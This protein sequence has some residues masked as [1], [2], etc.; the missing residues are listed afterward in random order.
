MAFG[1]G[2]VIRELVWIR[3]FHVTSILYLPFGRYVRSTSIINVQP[4]NAID[5]IQSLNEWN[6]NLDRQEWTWTEKYPSWQEIRQY[7]HFADKKLGIKKDVAFES[8][9]ISAEFDTE[10]LKW[11]VKT[12]DGRTAKAKILI[13]ALGFAAKRAFPDW[14]GLENFKGEIYH[15]S[16]WPEEG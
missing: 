5:P 9:V 14:K 8:R 1:S 10:N 11:V 12:E 2:I 13:N 6:A 7:F 16:F 3:Q 4:A 15:S